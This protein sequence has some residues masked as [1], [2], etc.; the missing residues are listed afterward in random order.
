MENQTLREYCFEKRE[1]L[2]NFIDNVMF[3]TGE[4]IL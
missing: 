4:E 2:M 3:Q 1:E